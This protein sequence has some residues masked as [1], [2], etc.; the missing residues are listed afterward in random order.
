MRSFKKKNELVLNKY[1]LFI[2]FTLAWVGV[3]QAVLNRSADASFV[4]RM[5]KFAD[6]PISSNSTRGVLQPLSFI[7]TL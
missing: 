5:T 6:G 2:S 4:L 1:K 3:L 7:K